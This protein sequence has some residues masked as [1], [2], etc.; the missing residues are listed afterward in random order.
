MYLY[1]LSIVHL[2]HFVYIFFLPAL[3][4][5][6]TWKGCRIDPAT[7]EITG[8]HLVEDGVPILD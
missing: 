7:F 2:G 5:R 4:R 8:G 3:Y 1:R 6:W